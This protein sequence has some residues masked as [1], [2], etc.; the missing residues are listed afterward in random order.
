MNERREDLLSAI[1]HL[2]GQAEMLWRLPPNKADALRNEAIAGLLAERHRMSQPEIAALTLIPRTTVQAAM[3]RWLRRD[4]IERD[5]WRD[6]IDR[7]MRAREIVPR[8]RYTSSLS[9]A[10]PSATVGGGASP[11]DAH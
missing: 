6:A 1:S 2:T 4:A 3:T 11:T 8:S 9:Q 5:A 7:W 10:P